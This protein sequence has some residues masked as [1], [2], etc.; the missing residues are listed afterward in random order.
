MFVHTVGDLILCSLK[1]LIRHWKIT[2]SRHHI[3]WQERMLLHRLFQ[4]K[5]TVHIGNLSE[6]SSSSWGN[7][8]HEKFFFVFYIHFTGLETKLSNS[9]QNVSVMKSFQTLWRS[10]S[11]RVFERHT[12][13]KQAWRFARINKGACLCVFD[14]KRTH[15]FILPSTEHQ[16]INICYPCGGHPMGRSSVLLLHCYISGT[17]AIDWGLTFI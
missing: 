6:E 8:H 7:E 17:D 16:K 14:L 10:K 9:V 15:A 13:V 1:T 3:C 4:C 11:L 5:P 12:T 2:S